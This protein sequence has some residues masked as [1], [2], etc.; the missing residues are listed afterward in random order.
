MAE[1]AELPSSVALRLA[2]RVASQASRKSSPWIRGPL[3][4]GFWMQNA[5][6]LTP[7][8]L[9]LAHGY[10]DPEAGPLDSLYFALTALFW[11]GHRLCSTWLAYC[12]E[13]CR[14]LL[15]SQPIRF[16]VIPSVVTVLCFAVFLP[17][18]DALPWSRADRLVAFAI[19]DYAW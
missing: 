2:P 19:I 1:I 15:R 9:W 10:A 6:W 3:W 16:I 5:L 17:G 18:D 8:V 13:A 11:I 7:I 4:D 14:P 12:T